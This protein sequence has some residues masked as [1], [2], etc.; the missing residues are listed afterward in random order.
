MKDNEYTGVAEYWFDNGNPRVQAYF[1]EKHHR[2]GKYT[3]WQKNGNKRTEAFF[4]DGTIVGTS[5]DY[6]DDGNVKSV[7]RYDYN[8]ELL[9]YDNYLPGGL[10]ER[11]TYTEKGAVK[12]LLSAKSQPTMFRISNA[13][14]EIFVS[15]AEN[16]LGKIKMEKATPEQWKKMLEKEGGL[17]AGEDKWLGLSEWL[18]AS[19]RKTL[20]KDEVA[21]FIAEN[22]IQIEETHYSEDV[23]IRKVVEDDISDMIGR[24]KSLEELQAEIDELV[25][26]DE[27]KSLNDDEEKD[28]WLLDQMKDRYG[29]DFELGYYIDEEQKISYSADPWDYDE[30]E[31]ND[32]LEIKAIN[33]VRKGYT[34]EGLTNKHEIALTVPTIEP[35]NESDKIHFG[36]AGEGRAVSW[37]R[38][39]DTTVSEEQ[40]AAEAK[41]REAEQA[42]KD[43][44]Q[45]VV[46]K[47]ALQATGSKTTLDLATPEETAK[48]RELQK[49]AQRL[50]TE[51]KYGQHKKDKVLVI[52]EIQSKR[53]QEAREHGYND[54]KNVAELEKKWQEASKAYD[55][56]IDS[57]KAKYGG[58]N[59]MAGKV[60]EEENKKAMELND[61]S[62]EAANAVDKAKGGIPAAP[63]E[64]N[65]PELTMKRMLRYAAEGGYKYMAW[66]TGEQ[67]A[68]RYNLSTVID[69][70]ETVQHHDGT[71]ERDVYLDLAGDRE[72]ELHVDKEGKV[73]SVG[74]RQDQQFVGNSLG[75]I[76]GKDLAVKAMSTK[77]DEVGNS[78]VVAEG[79]Q[80]KVGGAGMKGFYDEI[81]PRWMNKY[82]KQWGVKVEDIKLPWLQDENGK[83]GITMHSVPITDEMRESVMEGQLMFRRVIEK[84]EDLP[85]NQQQLSE[86][87]KV[88]IGKVNAKFNDELA[89]TTEDNVGNMKYSLGFPSS[90]LLGA[91]VKDKEM[92]LYGPKLKSKAQKHGFKYADIKDL[93]AATADPIAVFNNHG[94][95][96]NRSIL[97]EIKLGDKNLLVAVNVGK[98]NDVDFNII[99]SVMDKRG[100]S[101]AEWIINDVYTYIN[102]E[103]ALNYLQTSA[104]IAVS[105][106]ESE[107]SSE[108]KGSENFES[109]NNS[110]KKIDKL[111]R[112]DTPEFS[113]AADLVERYD[114]QD[115]EEYPWMSEGELISAVE[116]N[117]ERDDATDH[118]FEL[119]DR[120]HRLEEENFAEG[121]RDFAG[122]E[123][124]ELFNEILDELR[125][126]EPA[127]E[128]GGE[129]IRFKIGETPEEHGPTAEELITKVQNSG[130]P[131]IL[132]KEL[133]DDYFKTAYAMMPEGDRKAAAQDAISKDLNFRRPVR[134]YIASLAAK[135]YANDE[136]GFLRALA[137]KLT[138]LIS[139][140]QPLS[141][142]QLLYMMWRDAKRYTKQDVLSLAQDIYLRKQLGIGEFVKPFPGEAEAIEQQAEKN[143]EVADEVRS[144]ERQEAITDVKKKRTAAWEA[145]N[146]AMTGQRQYDRATVDGIVDLAKQMIREGNI[147]GVTAREMGR[148]MTIIK[149][150]NGRRPETVKN[151]CKQLMDFIVDHTLQTEEDLLAQL[152]KVKTAKVKE[153]GV[154]VMTKLD[155]RTQGIINTFKENIGLDEASIDNKIAEIQSKIADD[156][157]SE[158]RKEELQAQLEGLTLAKQYATEIAANEANT[159]ALREAIK[160]AKADFK[161]LSEAEQKQMEKAYREYYDA[162]YDEIRRNKIE[163]VNAYRDLRAALGAAISEGKDRALSFLEAEKQRIEK[164]HHFAN[165]DLQGV[166]ATKASQK[167]KKGF[168]KSISGLA[169]LLASPLAN[170]E[171]LFRVLGRRSPDGRGYLYQYFVPKIMQAS[172]NQKLGEDAAFAAINK[173]LQEIYNDPSMSLR[174]LYLKTR[175][176][177][178]ATISYMDGSGKIVTEELGQGQLLYI[179]MVDKMP[180]GRMKLREM[181]ITEDQVRDIRDNLDPK[182]IEFADW[183]Q[184]DFLAGLRDKYNEVHKRMFGTSMA[185][186]ENY[187]PL[188]IAG[189]AI[190]Q[191][192]DVNGN[193]PASLASTLTGAIIKRTV[194]KKQLDLANADAFNVLSDHIEEMEEWA[195]FAEV[196]KD[197]NTL[198][199]YDRFRNQVKHLK[200]VFGTN[201]ELW[202]RVVNTM[203]L[204]VK[205]YNGKGKEA[206]DAVLNAAKAVSAAK[207][208]FR[209]Y[210]ALKQFLSFPAYITDTSPEYLVKS[211]AT[212]WESWRWAM[213]NLPSFKKRWQSG[214]I[215]NEKLEKSESDWEFWDSKFGQFVLKDGMLPNRAV[216]ALTVSIGAK[217][218]YDTKK[219]KYM[220]EG[221][222]EEQADKKAKMDAELLFNA[223]QQS[224]ESLFL[225]SLQKDRTV[226]SNIL[227][228]FRNASM[229]Y[230]RQLHQAIR[231]YSRMIGHK[232][233]NIEF[234]TK[235]LVREG[236]DEDQAKKVANQRYNH[237]LVNNAVRMAVFGFML[238]FA[239]NLGSNMVYLLFGDDDDKKKEMLEEDLLRAGLGGA[240]EG[241]AGGNAISEALYLIKKGESLYGKDFLQLPI[242]SDMKNFLGHLKSD[243]VRSAND[244]VNLAFQIGLGSNPQ[245]VS[246]AIVAIVDAC[247]GDME[248]A[249][250]AMFCILRILQVPQSQLDELMIDE[251]GMKA[252]DARELT[253][254]EV[255]QR[256]TDYKMDRDAA[257]TKW[258]YS[259]ELRE[260]REKENK[261]TFKKKYNA[262]KKLKEQE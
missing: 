80:L 158:T 245:V 94:D 123:M 68:E 117:I 173:K 137:Q 168:V 121:K 96:N 29:D 60:T 12:E 75:D 82:G 51:W 78:E 188:K 197:I 243:P 43:Y 103:K 181:G 223:T 35:W 38:F 180:D 150:T 48:V 184:E 93:P 45:E 111:F 230:Q 10:I 116:E 252:K 108:S 77:T 118:L 239:W 193:D 87:E 220:K 192:V 64:K 11:T 206:D 154:D 18:D 165:S 95:E 141:E 160:S 69:R 139:T 213:K 25:D 185:A 27:Y 174:D 81:L 194:N 13:N 159:A 79:E 187:F 62:I 262:R 76:I 66:T 214:T 179:Y 207:V 149:S 148:L 84:V 134:D 235:Q 71:G 236:L 234:M 55:D 61:A 261:K 90:I 52:D 17:K 215:G 37:A 86:E 19:D 28:E 102:K 15:N 126:M 105:S 106:D 110:E 202:K 155:V 47:Y 216:D 72:I 24:G 70:I 256:Y 88:E 85:D 201:E 250:E 135:G 169:H 16:A 176:A 175:R 54:K 49:E 26:S 241:F 67:Q 7:D 253:Y 226:I 127:E 101:V 162:C 65:W 40:D 42:A 232:K 132:D 131:G 53:H 130:L 218:I 124:E 104:P 178:K 146:R 204:A 244:L 152:L 151:C 21:A 91:G 9:G 190:H 6:D 145:I 171:Q 39:G 14:Q 122:G 182:L 209:V 56:Y 255:A 115:G 240:V 113:T 237:L 177:P 199:S 172:D 46:N 74:N 196:R 33:S 210:T 5:I 50:Y 119:I 205:K 217:A 100:E 224:S 23:N 73:L 63:F 251:I 249:K 183:V 229:G 147:N 92:I 200:T 233:D 164:I 3:L 222:S 1:N 112:I 170:A 161:E 211:M 257:M 157:T 83:M 212:P 31:V 120:Y 254:D 227:T 166:P 219:R 208:N 58:Y 189:G 32:R 133:V 163:R 221:F 107:P 248:T 144:K 225:S 128:E 89:K 228:V 195:A 98:G 125:S 242:A 167:E 41:F 143:V 57:L 129:D 30:D 191:E 22:K 44:K 2:D 153:P 231:S 186:I 99:A 258:A 138:D 247:N 260:A 20:T 259:D 34:T 246:D 8:G 238:Q 36:D 198:L 142:N 114:N 203:T 136:T 97:T 140:D 59:E 156:R 4:K 109:A